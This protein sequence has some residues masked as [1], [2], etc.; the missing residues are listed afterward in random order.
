MVSDEQSVLVLRMPGEEGN[1]AYRLAALSR[2]EA[3]RWEQLLASGDFAAIEPRVSGIFGPL[4]D[5]GEAMDQLAEIR[6]FK[7]IDLPGD[8]T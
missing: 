1:Y 3:P 2:R 5:L 7:V 8:P 6:N 4:I